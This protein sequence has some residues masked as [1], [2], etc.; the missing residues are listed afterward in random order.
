MN[1]VATENT[2]APAPPA[3]VTSTVPDPRVL[4]V[5]NPFVRAILQ[6]PL[7]PLA[8]P[9]NAQLS[10]TRGAAPDAALA[11]RSATGVTATPCL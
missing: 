6:S 3:I 1:T 8:Q 11:C 2:A 7:H 9:T 5:I 4:R 10:P